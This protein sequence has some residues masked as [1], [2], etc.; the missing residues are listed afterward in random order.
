MAIVGFT[1]FLPLLC[2]FKVW[3]H[4]TEQVQAI[5]R[6]HSSRRS[7]LLIASYADAFWARR[8]IFLPYKRLQNH[9]AIFL[10][11]QSQCTS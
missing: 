8:T 6:F 10:V 3:F 2:G 4:G 9:R 7:E 5:I 1:H 11:S